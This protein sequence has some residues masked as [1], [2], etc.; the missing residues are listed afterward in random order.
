MGGKTVG[1]SSARN[2]PPRRGLA[3]LALRPPLNKHSKI[4]CSAEGGAVRR[5]HFV[6]QIIRLRHFGFQRVT[7]SWHY[8]HA[9]RRF[10][11]V[12]IL[13][14]ALMAK[15]ASICWK[16]SHMWRQRGSGL[17]QNGKLKPLR[18]STI[19]SFINSL[20][21][22]VVHVWVPLWQLFGKC[23]AFME[24][25]CLETCF[26]GGLIFACFG[27]RQYLQIWRSTCL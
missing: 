2:P 1:P 22:C 8:T 5:R 27:K 18:S 24:G 11:H 6:S 21:F 9:R 4:D 7:S 3:R 25:P 17:Q 23:I 16:I 12:C 20:Y 14:W 10:V 26:W 13:I 15:A 19:W